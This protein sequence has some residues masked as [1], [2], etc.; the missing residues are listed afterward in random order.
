[1]SAFQYQITLTCDIASLSSEFSED[2]AIEVYTHI[3]IMCFYIIKR[4]TREGNSKDS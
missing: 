4:V 2:K 1:M 3:Q